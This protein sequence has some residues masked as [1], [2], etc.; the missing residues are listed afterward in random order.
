MRQAALL[1]FKVMQGELKRVTLLLR[2]TGEVTRVQGDAVL[3]WNVEPASDSDERRLVVQLNQ[4]QKDAF[5]L[6]VQ[7]QTPAGRLP[8][9][10]RGGAIAAGGRDPLRRL[11]PHRQ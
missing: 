6:Q 1:N 11:L 10:H 4:P 3:A 2:G 7:V 8:A 5:A 9:D